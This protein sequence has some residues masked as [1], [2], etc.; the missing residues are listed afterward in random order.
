MQQNYDDLPLLMILLLLP[1]G[2]RENEL[3]YDLCCCYG[4]KPGTGDGLRP[5]GAAPWIYKAV[6]ESSNLEA[7]SPYSM[8]GIPSDEQATCC[9]VGV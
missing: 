1:K 2:N 5:A 9:E 6:K 8:F 7:P 3:H 4:L